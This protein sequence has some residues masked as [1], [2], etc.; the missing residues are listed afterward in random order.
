M[1]TL[2]P[3]FS[4]ILMLA[5]ATGAAGQGIWHTSKVSVPDDL[6]VRQV[7]SRA[8]D[9]IEQQ[10]LDRALRTWQEALDRMSGKVISVASGPRLGDETDHVVMGDVFGSVRLRVMERIRTLPDDGLARYVRLMEPRAAE[11]AAQGR[12][13]SL[14]AAHLRYFLTPSGRKA[15]LTHV[16]IM[17]EQGRFPEAAFHAL[18]LAR[19]LEE[20]AV[21]T[22]LIPL[23][24]ARQA[25]ALW[26]LGDRD[27]LSAL[28]QTPQAKGATARVA[29][30]EMPLGDYIERLVEKLPEPS[31]ATAAI[32][33]P[34]AFKLRS[35]S[36][37]LRRNR[38]QGQAMVF[39]RRTRRPMV[40]YFPVV[41]T[42]AGGLVVWCDGDSV[43]AQS[44]Y[45]NTD[46][47]PPVQGQGG[48]ADARLNRNLFYHTVVDR[49]LIFAN[50]R[51]RDALLSQR[52]W[53][54]FQPIETIPSH[55]LI[56]VDA[57]TGTVVW[58]HAHPEAVDPAESEFLAA[59]N[60]NQ[61]PLVM[62][63]TLYA[64]GTVL[65]GVFY[66][67]VCAIER[68][69]G[70]ILWRTYVGSGQ[71]ELNMFGNPIK[72]GVPGQ[73]AAVDGV[74]YYC[75]NI[76]VFCALDAPTGAIRWIS[77]YEQE[78]IPGTDNPMTAERH[79]GWMPSAPAVYEDKIYFAPTDSL[80]LYVADRTTGRLR[81]VPG[82]SRSH[83]TRNTYF[84]GIHGEHVLLAG[85]RITALR[86]RD[87]TLAWNTVQIQNPP[88]G[89]LST[90]QGR[91]AISGGL[92]WYTSPLADGRAILRTANL[93]NGAARHE[94]VTAG[95]SDQVG[96]VVV[97]P[98]AVLVAGQYQI[99]AHF[100]ARK[101][102]QELGLAIRRNPGNPVL[103]LQLADLEQRQGEWSAA[104]E[105]F[106]RALKAAE[107][108]GHQGRET[109]RRAGLALYNGWMQLAREP[110]RNLRSG[111]NNPEERF[112]KALGYARSDAQRVRTLVE[113]LEVAMET[114]DSKVFV[115]TAERIVRE[116]PDEWVELRGALHSLLPDYP[117]GLLMPA[118]LLATVASGARFEA[119]KRWPDALSQYHFAQVTWPDVPL[120]KESTWTA[121]GRRIQG[122]VS[123]G[124]RQVYQTLEREA[125][126]ALAEARRLNDLEGIR[127]VLRRYPQSS[128]VE[129]AYLEL[130]R[131]LITLG[132]LPGALHEM[133]SALPRFGAGSKDTLFECIRILD[134]LGCY[135]SARDL[136]LNLKTRFPTAAIVAD[137]SNAP[138]SQW[139]DRLL[140]EDR[141]LSPG[142]AAAPS[143]RGSLR[144]AWEHPTR[145]APQVRLLEIPGRAPA[146][147]RDMALY[148][149]GRDLVA[150]AA[151]S[152]QVLWR[153][154]S[155]RPPLARFHD[156]RLVAAFDEQV[157]CLDPATG[158]EHWRTQ[159]AAGLLRDLSCG[160]GKVYLLQSTLDAGRSLEV[161]ALDITGGRLVHR[162]A[163]PGFSDG[164]LS[165][166]PLY[167]AVVSS[168]E[169]RAQAMDGI[170]S[171]TVGTPLTF[172]DRMAP[173]LT[174]DNHMVVMYG[175][176][177]GNDMVRL[178]G[179]D[180]ATGSLR[181]SEQ[182]AV[183]TARTL[184]QD[185]DSVA[186]Q[187]RPYNSRGGE[188][189]VIV[190]ID[191]RRGRR[192]ASMTLPMNEFAH[193]GL[194]R[195]G[196]LYAIAMNTVRGNQ[197][198]PQR[199]HAY[200]LAMGRLLWST[201]E[202]SGDSVELA[203]ALGSDALLIHKMITG[204]VRDD[205]IGADELYTVDL[206]GGRVVDLLDLQ[207]A[208]PDR[209]RLPMLVRSGNLI[210]ATE[211][212]IRGLRP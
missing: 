114:G 32:P 141:F 77:A 99:S 199:V 186:V 25:H 166:S 169:G 113:C 134:R 151:T 85:E 23:A 152:G 47:W 48:A 10:D 124:G 162:T 144:L 187:V 93:D 132:D 6:V 150:L 136:A 145:D 16:D 181:F 119:A 188:E 92:V 106:D 103:L 160:H 111:P 7:M 128:V 139:V 158:E 211:T 37:S 8:E 52:A 84:L 36:Q 182:I 68:D 184:Y 172:S 90:I 155:T 49:D 149:D 40:D 195:D 83:A 168:R 38:D 63:D 41:P 102:M 59:L 45:T 126:N 206:D 78:P 142:S 53:H 191:A 161:V 104:L 91:P 196:R 129:Q 177:R 212:G 209:D 21:G 173:F 12:S 34:N 143:L 82:A 60:I 11:L 79:P 31:R 194:V 80:D 153:R 192:I 109:A 157:V 174:E 197:G 44:L 87:G 62:G 9:A 210:L 55:K 171:E 135:D 73:I 15:A 39:D 185:S 179:V 26:A 27:A 20:V 24:I 88:P 46:A 164:A 112:L 130:S 51:G 138:A 43:R 42:V 18:A 75:T 203:I 131:A 64:A 133:L 2:R 17:L 65:K 167:V 175:G 69:T 70:R 115:R 120:Y 35:W 71:Q 30:D 193:Q 56:A 137:G 190:A 3:P 140:G 176:G 198:L 146:A 54:G 180:P 159:P 107:R 201:V 202:F 116:H 105:T 95:P 57:S 86:A 108:Q 154:S 14:R 72:E 122:L 22:E 61:P 1:N 101:L 178:A 163:F 200:D 189:Q 148:H 170:T 183:G 67:W 19:E 58:N 121:M 100:D 117:S 127:T 147:A 207:S 123:R 118:G 98:E 156:G 81:S 205:R 28:L 94:I 125:V 66:H 4:V 110:G 89:G 96:N 5:V 74:L 208:A 29:G 33:D 13:E 50:L 204:R 76:G 97:T 165:V